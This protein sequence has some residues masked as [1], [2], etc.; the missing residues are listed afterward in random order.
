MFLHA[1]EQGQKEAERFIWWG[2]WQ[3]LPRPDPG[4]DL[5]TMKIVGYWLSNKEIRD[6]YHS[7]YLLRRSPGL[8]PCG[9]Q[10]RKEAIWDILSSL[11]NCL[12]RQVYPAAS[13][14]DVRGSAT[15]SQSR[16]RMR[17]D[18]HEEALQ[19]ARTAH[20][21]ALEADQVLES[22]IK[23]LSGG[24]EGCLISPPP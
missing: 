22:D 21:R 13:K 4:A 18:P 5:P 19:E 23:R 6:L 10:Q 3:N 14:E 20:Q 9:S 15:E 8:L 12:H 2:C 7:I 16:S 1:A 24:V 11:R 17:E